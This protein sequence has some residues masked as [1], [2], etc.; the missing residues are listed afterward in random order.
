MLINGHVGTLVVLTIFVLLGSRAP[1]AQT[2]NALAKVKTLQCVFPVY[3]TG[4]WKD[5]EPHAEVRPSNLSLRFDAIDTDE[6]T[7]RVT[8]K[9]GG[10]DITARLSLWS[11]TFMQMSS[12]GTLYI[13]TVF[14]KQSRPGEFR[15]VHTRHEYT[16]VSLP[17]FTSS[18]EQYY[19]ECATAP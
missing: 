13:T 9:F 4:T 17:G 11:L 14:D 2:P 10:I 18:P 6:G 7:A 3:A 15:A 5:G 16:P 1:H 12:W 19:G 8:E